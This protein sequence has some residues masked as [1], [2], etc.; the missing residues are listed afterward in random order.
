[1]LKRILH[2]LIKFIPINILKIFLLRKIFGYK[3]GNN[4]VI[5]KSIINCNKV[6]I[7]DNVIIESNSTISCNE[8]KIGENS[9]ILSG[10]IIIGSGNFS[11]G[12]NSRI[13]NKHFFDLWNNIEIGNN[14]WIAGKD[15]QFWTHGSL[16][17]KS[18]SNLSIYIGDN[19]YVGSGVKF[20]PGTTISS[21][22]LIALGAVVSGKFNEEE[23]IIAGNLATVIKKN[24]YWRDNW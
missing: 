11:I 10:N 14:T 9:K 3:I 4:V 6:F 19:V 20:S 18:E 8:F 13:I 17:S 7:G 15:S 16:K 23:T 2:V 22:N 5:K 21:K 24:V 12:N 1:M